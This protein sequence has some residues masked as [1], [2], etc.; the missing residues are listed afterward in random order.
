MS[1]QSSRFVS[2]DV[3]NSKGLLVRAGCDLQSEKIGRLSCLF[4]ACNVE[5]RELVYADMAVHS[6]YRLE[7]LKQSHIVICLVT[8]PQ[9]GKTWNMF[10]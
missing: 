2:Q 10:W 7:N 4:G 3:R 9:L 8:N 5:W 6:S 1:S